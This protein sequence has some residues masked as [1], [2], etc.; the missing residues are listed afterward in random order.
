MLST[1]LSP[2]LRSV[3]LACVLGLAACS[4]GEERA[5]D[6]LLVTIDTLRPDFLSAYGHPR[7][8]T[9]HIDSLAQ[10]G[11]LFE[12]HY[13]VTSL[14]APSHASLFTG[15]YPSEH[16]V[17]RNGYDFDP[18]L[19][20]LPEVLRAAGYRTAGVVAVSLIGERFGFAA[21]FE[22]FDDEIEG[23]GRHHQRPGDEVVERA[24]AALEREDERPLFLWVHLF[25]PHDPYEAPQPSGL[26]EAE[27]RALFGE[28]AEPTGRFGLE[29]IVDAQLAYEDEV[30]YVDAQLGRLLGAW[31]ARG[32]RSLVALTADHG[33]G[34]GE[35]RMM[36]HGRTLYEEQVH[37]PLVLRM[38]E[39]VPAGARIGSVSSVVDLSATLLDLLGASAEGAL[40]GASL[41]ARWSGVEPAEP[42][43]AILECRVDAERVARMGGE[44]EPGQTLGLQAA[45]VDASS[46]YIWT[47]TAGAE[48][49]ALDEDP[50][51][52]DDR[53]DAQGEAPLLHSRRLQ[54]WL[55]RVGR[56]RGSG[57]AVDAD[58]R[59]MLDALGY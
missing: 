10:A 14:T 17:W 59:A 57:Q 38:P 53:L 36:G 47:P 23:G 48:L 39:V 28:R 26:D 43:Y 56:T 49:Y 19:T 13:T 21:G 33:E 32:R 3:G 27:G 46:K 52:S 55:T 4:G 51:E 44:L 42:P 5:P 11:A 2:R 24:L 58:T 1:L 15:L 8:T 41:R 7:A 30:A 29:A 25:D 12:R 22:E 35:H 18:Q 9:P 45:V 20:R 31:D 16:G 40:P 37:V 50:A 34:L 6:L 54:S